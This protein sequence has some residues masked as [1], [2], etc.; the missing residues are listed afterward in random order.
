MFKVINGIEINSKGKITGRVVIDSPVGKHI[1]EMCKA[2][3]H[4][5]VYDEIRGLRFPKD[6]NYDPNAKYNCVGIRMEYTYEDKLPAYKIVF[7]GQANWK[8][9]EFL[10][11]LWS[12]LPMEEKDRYNDGYF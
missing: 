10:N 2:T 9:E 8:V 11:V 1:K 4:C 3:A 5:K 6:P 12:A 7:C